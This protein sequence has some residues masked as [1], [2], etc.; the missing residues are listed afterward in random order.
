MAINTPPGA[1]FMHELSDIY[2]EERQSSQRNTTFM[3][4]QQIHGCGSLLRI[5]LRRLRDKSRI[6]SGSLA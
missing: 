2:D 6:Q 3:R 1:K 4:L 5:T